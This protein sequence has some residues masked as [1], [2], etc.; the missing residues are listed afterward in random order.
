MTMLNDTPNTFRFR[1]ITSGTALKWVGTLIALAQISACQAPDVTSTDSEVL[2]LPVGRN[3]SSFRANITCPVRH[4]SKERVLAGATRI[5]KSSAEADYLNSD[6]QNRIAADF[7]FFSERNTG[8][9][10]GVPNSTPSAY[11]IML[12]DI[13]TVNGVPHYHYYGNKNWN[14]PT[15][16]WSSAKTVGVGI[17]LH[18]L[19]TLTGGRVGGDATFPGG[20]I[21]DDMDRVNDE[22]S[23]AHGS[24][25][26]AMSGTD[27]SNNMIHNWLHR[28][29]D[30]FSSFHGFG[31]GGEFDSTVAFTAPDGFQSPAITPDWTNRGSNSLAMMTQAEYMKR[32][33]VNFRD[34]IQLPKMGDYNTRRSAASLRSAQTSWTKADISTLMFGDFPSGG[35]GG[36]M[37]DGMRDLPRNF[38]LNGHIPDVPDHSGIEKISGG[39]WTSVGKGGSGASDSRG[40]KEEILMD[41]VCIPSVNGG[42]GIEFAIAARMS[43]PLGGDPLTRIW[44]TYG[45]VIDAVYPGIRKGAR[46][47]SGVTTAV[48]NGE[49]KATFETWVK[50]S[51]ADSTTL[52]DKDKCLVPV[53]KVLA[54][55]SRSV[56]GSHTRLTLKAADT[57]CPG[58]GRN[59]YVFTPHFAFVR[60]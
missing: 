5:Y 13:R 43:V 59:V 24:W 48:E 28:P 42:E 12:I 11:S 52:S 16:T 15:E 8:E 56:E 30:D 58:L 3:P 14:A 26:K 32:V 31:G 38:T 22:S 29:K 46:L 37:Y 20:S 50:K 27:F 6:W 35:I 25:Y 1:L 9:P 18:K 45:N 2:N 21:R 23:N 53:G 55:S 17:F 36:M 40:K 57:N 19:R 60:R 54:F 47:G 44:K 10:D 41:Y 34:E 39:D 4:A 7:S 49:A 51:P 33:G